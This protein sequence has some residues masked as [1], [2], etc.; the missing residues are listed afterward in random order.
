MIIKE[1][2]ADRA[3]IMLNTYDAIF[4]KTM[5]TIKGYYF[6]AKVAKTDRADRNFVEVSF[7]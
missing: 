2:S 3:I 6:D 7:H 1:F 4:M 5:T